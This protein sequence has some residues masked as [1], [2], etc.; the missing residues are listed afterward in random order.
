[1]VKIKEKDRRYVR[2]RRRENMREKNMR[3]RRIKY[4]FLVAQTTW[5]K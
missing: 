4:S 1:M 2:E 3:A 5:H